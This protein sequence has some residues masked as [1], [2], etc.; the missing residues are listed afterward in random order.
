MSLTFTAQSCKEA[1]A[2]PPH[3]LLS[4]LSFINKGKKTTKPYPKTTQ[5]NHCEDTGSQSGLMS[6]RAWLKHRYL[7]PCSSCHCYAT[8]AHSIS[9]LVV[10]YSTY[11]NAF[12]CGSELLTI[13]VAQRQNC[14]SA[15]AYQCP[16]VPLI[17]FPDYGCF[18]CR[19]LRIKE[20]LTM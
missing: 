14:K 9:C 5:A 17:T 19:K 7:S 10:F 12:L 20:S 15:A 16:W 11:H 3:C 2:P 13:S 4:L 1:P 8:K 18:S 6:Q